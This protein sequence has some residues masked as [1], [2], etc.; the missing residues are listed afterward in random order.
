VRQSL[1]LAGIGLLVGMI[2]AFAGTRVLS[3]L[4]YGVEP[5]D[6]TAFVGAAGLLLVVAF[7][8]SWIP[9]RRAARVDPSMA[10]REA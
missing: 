6:P 2:A 8:A 5:T 4:L 1:G 10:L 9:A 7:L 3:G